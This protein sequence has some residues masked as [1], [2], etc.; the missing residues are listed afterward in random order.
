MRFAFSYSFLRAAR[1]LG[2]RGRLS[3]PRQDE[4]NAIRRQAVLHNFPSRRLSTPSLFA[5]IFDHGV[6]GRQNALAIRSKGSS[7]AIGVMKSHSKR[8]DGFVLST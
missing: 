2:D 6:L 7:L 4:K 1:A 3:V 5:G 8:A